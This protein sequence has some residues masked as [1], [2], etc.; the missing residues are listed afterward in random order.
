MVSS[1]VLKKIK[2]FHGLEDNEL[3]VIAEFCHELTVEDGK[4]CFKQGN[5]STNLH[6]CVKGN[7]DILVWISEPWGIEIKVHT[8]AEG[9]IFGWS[10]LVEPYIYTASAKCNG[11]VEE[12]YIK[13][14][15]LMR[16]CEQ[17]PHTGFILLRNLGAIVSSRLTESR[18]KLVKEIAASINKDW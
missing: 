9:E 16:V 15:D 14:S 5:Q 12:I 1:E 18:E 10:A 6:F 4:L 2:F 13:G 11:H 8:V 17:Y 7:V 3:A